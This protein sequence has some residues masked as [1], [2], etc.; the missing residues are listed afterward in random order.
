MPFFQVRISGFNLFES[1]AF[2]EMVSVTAD[3]K[4]VLE[5]IE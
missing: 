2:R 5:R 3:L 4:A 1:E